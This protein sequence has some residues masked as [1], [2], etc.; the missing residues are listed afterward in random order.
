MIPKF[1]VLSKKEEDLLYSNSTVLLER[2][3]KFTTKYVRAIC[4]DKKMSRITENYDIELVKNMIKLGYSEIISSNVEWEKNL[5]KLSEKHS[6]LDPTDEDLSAVCDLYYDDMQKGIELLEIDDHDKSILKSAVRKRIGIGMFVHMK[7]FQST[8]EKCLEEREKFYKAITD[9][10]KIRAE[11]ED[12]YEMSIE[13]ILREIVTLIVLDIDL[14]LVWIGMARPNEKWIKIVSSAGKSSKYLND[15]KISIDPTIPEEWGPSGIS[16]LT[17]KPFVTNSFDAPDFRMWKEKADMYDIGGSANV[18]FKTSDGNLWNISMYNE[19]GKRFPEHIE[20][21]LNDLSIELKILIE[22]KKRATEL[23]KLRNYEKGLVK[24]Y[25]LLIKNPPPDIIYNMI[26]RIISEHTD[27]LNTIYMSIP[28]DN[29]EWMKVIAAAGKNANLFMTQNMVSINL[30]RHPEG[31]LATSKSFREFRPVIMHSLD[32]ERDFQILWEKYPDLKVKSVGSWPIFQNGVE[33][34]V[35]ILTIESPES[36]YFTEDLIMLVEKIISSIEMALDQ[37]TSKEKIEWLSLHDPLTGLPNRTYFERSANDAMKRADR[38]HKKIM[39]GFMDIDNF[40]SWND[41][42]GHIAGDKLLKNIG[43]TLASILRGG[44]VIS[45]MGGDEFLFH[46]IFEKYDDINE[47]IKRV[48]NAISSVNVK[49]RMKV[50]FSIGWAIYPDE[51]TDL[52]ELVNIADK[53]M[54]DQKKDD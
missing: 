13:G 4:A 30:E 15:I 25:R 42:F 8:Q 33:K 24:I 20:N 26:V 31:W 23:A 37:Y 32:N 27:N 54:Y 19:K 29:S 35:A 52:R 46:I 14:S 9:V 21:L 16:V 44:D 43:I 2:A 41:T 11:Y 38:E 39:I 10:S 47:V 40:K 7:A 3:D 36:D 51:S 22:N 18:S 49:H 6:K 28:R 5:E 17:G 34:P 50:D 12:E 53:R 45:R 1:L 48:N